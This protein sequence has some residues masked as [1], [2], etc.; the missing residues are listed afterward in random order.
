MDRIKL[1]NI[2]IRPG[3]D[4]DFLN[5]LKVC[6]RAAAEAYHLPGSEKLFSANHYFHPDM[7]SFWKKAAT[8]NDSNKWWVAEIMSPKSEQSV[9]GGICLRIHDGYSE[10]SGFYV[11]PQYQGQGIGRAL[12]Y[13]RQESIEVPLYF[14]VYSHA[15]KTIAYHERHGAVRTGRQRLIHWNS[16]PSDVNLTALEFISP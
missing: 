13:A 16:W 5:Y 12:W 2:I 15:A 11:D 3:E 10:G 1:T 7:M 8:N 6:Q 9:V 14:E 4:K